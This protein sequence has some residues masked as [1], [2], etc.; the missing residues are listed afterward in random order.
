MPQTPDSIRWGIVGTANIARAQFLP[1]LNEAGG[2]RATSVASRDQAKA[3]AYATAHGIDR[4]IEGYQNLVESPDIDAVYVALPNALH[5]EPTIR[6]LQAGKA[7]L[8][9]KPLS[10]GSASTGEVLDVAATAARPLWEAF[11]FPFQAQHQRLVRLLADGAIGRPAEIYSAFHFPLS[12]PANIRMDAAL[13]GGALADVGCYPVRL[14]LELFN[15]HAGGE[16]TACEAVTEN[17]VDTDAAGIV[18]FDDGRRL[19]LSC[20]FRRSFDTFST[21]LG[22]DGQIQLTNPFHPGPADTLTISRP[23]ADPVVERPTTD[24][25]SFTAAIRHIHAVLRGETAPVHT[26]SEYSLPAA[27]ILEQLQ[28]LAG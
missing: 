14:A 20:G 10:V 24:A 23:N 2:G 6:A 21:V 17:G 1:G 22:S 16:A 11:V 9:E 28:H 13:G 7:V 27:R 15:A 4:G 25:R 26:A 18:R 19:L 5:A 3:D 8:C 12:N